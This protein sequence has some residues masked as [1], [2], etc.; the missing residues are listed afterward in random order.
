MNKEIDYDLDCD[1]L[2]D[3]RILNKKEIRYCSGV[4][5]SKGGLSDY[6]VETLNAWLAEIKDLKDN[7]EYLVK[8]KK[9]ETMKKALVIVKEALSYFVRKV[10]NKI[11]RF[12]D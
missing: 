5:E 3:M 7:L 4:F 6:N 10:E 1:I 8:E 9:K 2:C 12:Y 11:W